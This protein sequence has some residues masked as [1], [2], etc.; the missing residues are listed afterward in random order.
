MKEKTYQIKYEADYF[1]TTMI[2]LAKR[3]LAAGQKRQASGIFWTSGT[4]RPS[5]SQ[6]SAR[7]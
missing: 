1:K 5:F 6:Y 7:Y 3:R 4:I 2:G